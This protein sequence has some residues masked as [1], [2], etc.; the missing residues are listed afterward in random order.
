MKKTFILFSKEQQECS[1]E[2]SS[3]LE[4]LLDTSQEALT[5][6]DLNEVMNENFPDNLNFHNLNTQD[7]TIVDN[8]LTEFFSDGSV[9]DH[10]MYIEI[11]TN[12][13]IL[14]NPVLYND[15]LT[16][17]Y[18][19]THLFTPGFTNEI[20]S[21]FF[22]LVGGSLLILSTNDVVDLSHFSH[23]TSFLISFESENLMT[24]REIHHDSSAATIQ[25][26]GLLNNVD[27]SVIALQQNLEHAVTGLNT[28]VLEQNSNLTTFTFSDLY[29]SFARNS[30]YILL[31]TGG[32]ILGINYLPNMMF[33]GRDVISLLP[34]N[35]P[36]VVENESVQVS[37]SLLVVTLY[38][39]IN[40]ILSI[41]WDGSLPWIGFL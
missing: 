22:E 36:L 26:N 6:S 33:L 9:P 38:N 39:T 21:E 19:H 1:D 23:F 34:S 3:S 14:N 17:L 41:P 29:S 24:L 37:S 16:Y 10:G 35:L 8:I 7:G 18:T 2:L 20:P 11:F 12:T 30:S 27:D 28:L 40:N 4:T 13:I 31:G 32:L 25:A 5:V 15:L